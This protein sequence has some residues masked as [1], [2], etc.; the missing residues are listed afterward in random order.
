MRLESALG[1]ESLCQRV[2]IRVSFCVF[3]LYLTTQNQ[4]S[5]QRVI[6]RNL[7]PR[8]IVGDIGSAITYIYHGISVIVQIE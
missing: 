7:F 4:Q 8:I 1:A 2:L 6:R 5:Q 3:G